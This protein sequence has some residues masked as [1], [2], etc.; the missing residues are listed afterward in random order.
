MKSNIIKTF[1]FLTLF[2]LI[3]ETYA[4]QAES[5][6]IMDY[7][8]SPHD[9][10]LMTLNGFSTEDF[11][12]LVLQSLQADPVFYERTT[13]FVAY[14]EF[15][16]YVQELYLSFLKY[17]Y[18]AIQR[19]LAQNMGPQS[20]TERVIEGHIRAFIFFLQKN[21]YLNLNEDQ[22]T[23]I[24]KNLLM[25]FNPKI[26]NPASEKQCESFLKN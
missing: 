24:R 10:V 19:D 3:K 4:G 26:K 23:K 7:T 6:F 17:F 5:T 25:V 14:P 20:N 9:K 22:I 11:Q 1:I 21:I 8:P 13:S 2:L 12:I 16:E 18:E 15:T